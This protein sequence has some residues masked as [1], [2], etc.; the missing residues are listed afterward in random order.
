MHF[1]GFIQISLKNVNTFVA[2]ASSALNIDGELQ[3]MQGRAFTDFVSI[4]GLVW[5]QDRGAGRQVL[6]HRLWA[7]LCQQS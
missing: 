7:P 4:V 6:N 5:L 2:N 1:R 3:F